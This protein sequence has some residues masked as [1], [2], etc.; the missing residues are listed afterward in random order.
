MARDITCLLCGDGVD[1]KEHIFLKC[2]FIRCVMEGFGRYYRATATWEDEL[3]GV[4]SRYGGDS[5]KQKVGRVVWRAIIAETWYNRC[6]RNAREAG[7]TAEEMITKI[8]NI[9]YVKKDILYLRLFRSTSIC[10]L[11]LVTLLKL[12]YLPHWDV[13]IIVLGCTCRVTCG[14]RERGMF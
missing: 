10:L 13:S 6:S 12:S 2:P 1:E 7:Q 5:V 14:T 8:K 4:S 9:L 11:F 3:E